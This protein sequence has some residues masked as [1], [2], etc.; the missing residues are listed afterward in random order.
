MIIMEFISKILLLPVSGGKV[1]GESIAAGN[2]WAE[3][4][5]MIFVVRRPG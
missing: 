5:A 1:V 2:L 3:K 4:P